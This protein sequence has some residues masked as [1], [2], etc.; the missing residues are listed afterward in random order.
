MPPPPPWSL[1][2]IETPGQ[3]R[4]QI[5]NPLTSSWSYG[6]NPEHKAGAACATV[7]RGSIYYCGGLRDGNQKSGPV[8][9]TCAVFNIPM[10]TWS[11]I[12]PM[13]YAVHHASMVTDGNF[14][15]VV[16]GRNVSKNSVDSPVA[17]TQIYN[18]ETK[19]WRSSGQQLTGGPK[20][21]PYGR[22]G[23]GPGISMY[24]SLY[25]FGGEVSCRGT[26]LGRCPNST[27]GLTSTGV[28]NRVDRY[29]PATDT[30]D[31]VFPMNVP[32]HGFYPVLGTAPRSAGGGPAVYVCGA[33]NITPSDF[34]GL[35]AL[36]MLV[37]HILK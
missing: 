5:Y 8:V 32:R 3:G 11:S 19:T 9:P 26:V 24:G 15:Y 20:A 28:F 35:V 25:F 23:M 37:H 4:M 21:M 33:G 34:A 27:I 22:G 1:T 7:L 13:P 31:R 30:W 17:F 16:G 10:G 29:T 36:V 14:V 12:P 6:P 18:P 2:S